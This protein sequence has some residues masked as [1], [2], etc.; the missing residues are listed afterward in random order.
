VTYHY[1]PVAPDKHK[2]IFS[3][4][5]VPPK[6]AT[7]RLAQELT[8]CTEKDFAI[9]DACTLEATQKGITSGARDKFHLSDQESMIRHF[10]Q[11]V[12]EDVEAY[13]RELAG[14]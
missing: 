14:K 5:F 2:F 13:K 12:Q 11:V 6:N 10:H 7:E 8:F 4:G 9:Q 1:W 3:V